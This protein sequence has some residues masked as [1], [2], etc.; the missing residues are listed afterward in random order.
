M[1]VLE[2]SSIDVLKLPTKQGLIVMYYAQNSNWCDRS[3]SSRP[4]NGDSYTLLDLVFRAHKQDVC[5]RN[6]G[7]RRPHNSFDGTSIHLLRSNHVNFHLHC[8]SVGR[9][10][11]RQNVSFL[12]IAQAK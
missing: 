10:K 5:G 4:Y 12:R 9:R 2:E 7:S 1:T 3:F 11:G 8:L 6:T